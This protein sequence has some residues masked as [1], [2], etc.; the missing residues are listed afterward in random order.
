MQITPKPIMAE[1]LMIAR[2]AGWDKIKLTVVSC[3]LSVMMSV[4]KMEL[5]QCKID[6][7]ETGIS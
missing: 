3:Q 5:I 1:K 6:G 4:A 2:P 7:V